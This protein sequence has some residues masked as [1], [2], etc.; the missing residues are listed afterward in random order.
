MRADLRGARRMGGPDR[1]GPLVGRAPVRGAPLPGADRGAGR[2]PDPARLGRPGSRSD[3]RAGM[4]LRE[5]RVHDGISAALGEAVIASDR[6]YFE[7][8]ARIES[9]A[10]ARLAWMPGL[11]D[12]TAG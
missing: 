6:R 11:A 1:R 10:G 8:G 9:V 5:T 3:P 12:L 4:T 7:L 2:R